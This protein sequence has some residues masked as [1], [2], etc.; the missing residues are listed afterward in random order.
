MRMPMFAIRM[1]VSKVRMEP[2]RLRMLMHFDWKWLWNSWILWWAKLR[3]HLVYNTWRIK[4]WVGR[5]LESTNLLVYLHAGVLWRW[6]DLASIILQ[7]YLP[8]KLQDFL[9]IAMLRS[10]I[11][12]HKLRSRRPI[13]WSHESA[14]WRFLL[15][16]TFLQPSR[17]SLKC[18][19]LPPSHLLGNFCFPKFS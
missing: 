4:M 14:L 1:C 10:F 5:I 13:R 7:V 19:R 3:L 18:D 16:T 8:L 9:R 2:R 15:T 6:N 17:P 11:R 12:L